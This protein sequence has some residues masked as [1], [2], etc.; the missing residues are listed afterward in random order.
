VVKWIDEFVNG[1]LLARHVHQARETLGMQTV[2]PGTPETGTP[3]MESDGL[4]SGSKEGVA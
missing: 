4:D 3:W 1:V 2:L